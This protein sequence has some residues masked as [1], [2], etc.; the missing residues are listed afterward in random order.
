MAYGLAKNL[1]EKGGK[2][3][4]S[5]ALDVVPGGSV[6]K[7]VVSTIT[8]LLGK[9]PAWQKAKD[10]VRKAGHAGDI[11]YLKAATGRYGT[12]GSKYPNVREYAQRYL[13]VLQAKSTGSRSDGWLVTKVTS[14]PISSGA[15]PMNAGGPMPPA[16]SLGS[17]P[18]KRRRRRHRRSS[19][20][21]HSRKA[22]T[23]RKSRS[24]RRSTSTHHRKR[25]LKF[26]SR[27]WRMKYLG[28]K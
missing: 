4:V 8:G 24:R 5:K 1:I 17:Y 7:G 6:V 18:P 25:K 22:K 19:Y 20:R 26:G 13:D 16:G 28:H 27:A 2:Q 14:P 9:G 12:P 3:I 10:R 11:E 23:H 21:S 15:G